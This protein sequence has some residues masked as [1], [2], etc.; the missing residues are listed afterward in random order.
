MQNWKKLGL[1]FAPEANDDWMI[2]HAAVPTIEKLT[3]TM[4]RVYFGSR[5]KQN[6]A[7]IGYFDFDINDPTNIKNISPQ[8][9][10]RPGELG[11]FDDSGVL[12]SWLVNNGNEK[13]MYY[14]GWNLGVTVPFRNF[15]GLA[16]SNG[17]DNFERFSRAPLADRDEADPFFFTN[18]CVIKDND[19]WKMWYLSTVR[20][21]EDGENVKHFYHIKYDESKDGIHW[22]R[23]PKVAIDFRY[24]NEYAISRPC[25]I[26]DDN[27]K[28]YMWYSYRAGPRGDT[29][30]IGYAESDNGIDW[31]R[32][33][34]EVGLDVSSGGWDEEMVAYPTVFDVNGD[35]YML[36]NGNGFGRSG[37]GLAILEK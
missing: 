18:P 14:I 32:K 12:P 16:R 11:T 10:L 7:S 8:P 35:R 15:I 26:K 21:E 25:V 37:I 30:R 2:T 3:D 24:D 19:S 9:I 1:V 22:N 34:E 17:D 29:Y 5:N 27:G 33:D 31:T 20:W 13:Y 36:Y 6:K 23:T 28:Y 4:F